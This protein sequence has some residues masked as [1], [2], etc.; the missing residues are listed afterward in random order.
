LT[1]TRLASWEEEW[2]Y[3]DGCEMVQ[4]AHGHALE[5]RVETT[6]LVFALLVMLRGA[7]L[8]GFMELLKIDGIFRKR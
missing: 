3:C 5:I 4:K 2:I 1:K 6:A 7:M 8:V